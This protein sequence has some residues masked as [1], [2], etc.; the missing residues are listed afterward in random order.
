MKIRLKIQNG[1]DREKIVVALANSGYK[2]RVVESKDPIY[3][4]RSNFFVD[5]EIEDEEVIDK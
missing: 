1:S 2:V 5:F 4:F 3:M